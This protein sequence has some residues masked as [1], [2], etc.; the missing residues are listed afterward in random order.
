[1]ELAEELHGVV[2]GRN[3]IRVRPGPVGG[4]RGVGDP[5]AAGI[6]RNRCGEA[7]FRCGPGRVRVAQRGSTGRV[8][9][10]GAVAY[11]SR[12]RVLGRETGCHITVF[13][14][15]RIARPAWL[16]AEQATSR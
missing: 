11:G 8:E 10:G 7:V 5:Q 15:E 6:T 13:G 4:T 14:S 12:Q 1:T 16:E 3:T 9:Q 2:K